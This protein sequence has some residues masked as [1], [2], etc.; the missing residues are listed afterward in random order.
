MS[1]GTKPGQ[2]RDKAM[3]FRW[4]KTLFLQQDFFALFK[5]WCLN[6][7]KRLTS[8]PCEAIFSVRVIGAI[9]FYQLFYY[10]Y[11]RIKGSTVSRFRSENPGQKIIDL[12]FKCRVPVPSLELTRIMI[13]VKAKVFKQWRDG[14][15]PP[16]NKVSSQP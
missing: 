2:K 8:S 4:T 7:A 15:G 16:S 11:S 1:P 6:K 13:K 9:D 5:Y 12:N 10:F 14:K 3:K